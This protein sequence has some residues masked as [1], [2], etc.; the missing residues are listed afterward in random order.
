VKDPHVQTG[1]QQI[2]IL[3]L[4][5]ILIDRTGISGKQSVP[6]MTMLTNPTTS[7]QQALATSDTG[8]L[9]IVQQAGAGKHYR[10][11]KKRT[12]STHEQIRSGH[13][14]A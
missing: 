5:N 12:A 2:T 14:I 6:L 4:K 13:K 7:R 3:V 10:R 1:Q 9:R 8:T 11:P